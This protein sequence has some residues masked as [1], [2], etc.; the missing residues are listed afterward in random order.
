MY[1]VDLRVGGVGVHDDQHGDGA[2]LPFP[3]IRGGI[4]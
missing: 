1:G 2:S 3:S 4:V